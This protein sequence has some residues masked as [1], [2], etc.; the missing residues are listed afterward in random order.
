MQT[1][2]ATNL[3]ALRM[4]GGYTMELLAEW[5]GVSRQ[6]IAKWEN[7]E[8]LPDIEKCRG[9]AQI[10]NV[11]LDAL[12]NE[13]LDKLLKLPEDDGRY[14]FGVAMVEEG[15]I[16]AL[17]QRAREVFEI[18]QGDILLVVGDKSKGIAMVKCEGSNSFLNFGKGKDAD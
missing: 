15:G 3:R 1:V 16:I 13:S 6:T 2:L 17:P 7:G 14:I 9:L 8:S 10:Y 11:S 12:V 4:H 18:E 5:I